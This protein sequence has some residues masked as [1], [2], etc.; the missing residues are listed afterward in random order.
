M[1]IN[2]ER[3]A[4]RDELK[5]FKSYE[6]VYIYCLYGKEKYKAFLK[7]ISEYSYCV[8]WDNDIAM[9]TRMR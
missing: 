7:L 5:E 9:I 3:K 6:P 2:Y 8:D 4:F 1:T